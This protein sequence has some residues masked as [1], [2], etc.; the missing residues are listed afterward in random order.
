[1]EQEFYEEKLVIAVRNATGKRNRFG[2]LD[3]YL[4]AVAG[5][6]RSWIQEAQGRANLSDI[7]FRETVKALG[8]DLQMLINHELRT[9]LTSV[10]GYL[11]LVRE[12][13]P[14]K[15]RTQWEE[16]CSIIT[17]QTSYVLEA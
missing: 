1:P 9:P 16:Y 8:V 5:R 4:E 15:E 3:G 7:G 6:I 17:S 10:A 2:E 11:S 13:D 12:L 14:L